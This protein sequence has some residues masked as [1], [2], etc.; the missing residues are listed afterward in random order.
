MPLSPPSSLKG[1]N[2]QSLLILTSSDPLAP[3]GDLVLNLPPYP[4]FLSVTRGYANSALSEG[5]Q[6]PSTSMN[7]LFIPVQGAWQ[8]T[9]AQHLFFLQIGP[10]FPIYYLWKSAHRTIRAA[11]EETGQPSRL[12]QPGKCG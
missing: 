11:G 5:S 9:R 4:G 12:R 6:Y 1:A 3:F 2:L 10:I 8:F 7:A